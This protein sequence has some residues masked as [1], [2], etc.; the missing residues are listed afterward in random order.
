LVIVGGFSIAAGTMTPVADVIQT[1]R[2]EIVNSDGK[3]VSQRQSAK[4]AASWIS[5][6]ARAR[7]PC[8]RAATPPAATWRCGTPAVRMSLARSR[9]KAEA[10][11]LCGTPRVTALCAHLGGDEGG[12]LDL[13]NG[14]DQPILSA[15]ASSKGG[16]I[17]VDNGQGE[18]VASLDAD[19]RGAGRL[20]LADVDGGVGLTAHVDALGGQFE[21]LNRSNVAVWSSGVAE[22]VAATRESR[23]S[24][25]CRSS[26]P[27]ATAMAA[28]E[29]MSATNR[30]TWCAPQGAIK[31]AGGGITLLNPPVTSSLRSDAR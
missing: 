24:R 22:T 8:A 7:T 17:Q 26:A 6:I 2:L 25:G 13:H 23:T 10:K 11:P 12:K 27:S 3:L 9:P 14:S 28:A 4:R 29:S 15:W 20:R 18:V 30:A 31:D 1:R 5:G 16:A 19:D 21:L